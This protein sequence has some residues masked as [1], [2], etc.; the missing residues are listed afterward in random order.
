MVK[1]KQDKIFYKSEG[2]NYFDRNGPRVNKSIFKAISFL[3]PKPNLNIFE[4]GCGCGSTLKKINKV[5]KSKVFGI[6]TSKKAIDYALK[7]TN[8][9][10][11][12]IALSCLLKQKKFDIIIT[13]GFYT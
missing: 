3:K 6:D 12:F 1:K 7:K 5:Y 4:I 8:L 13:G 2:D 10:K 9:K 11:C